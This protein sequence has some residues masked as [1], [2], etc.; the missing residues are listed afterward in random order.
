MKSTPRWLIGALAGPLLGVGL[1]LLLAPAS[2]Q[3][4]TVS[5]MAN[6]AYLLAFLMH[7]GLFALAYGV[8]L[9]LLQPRRAIAARSSLACMAVMA[10]LT[11]LHLADQL[12]FF[13]Q[14]APDRY[15]VRTLVG[16]VLAMMVGGL[17]TWL[18][19]LCGNIVASAT[20]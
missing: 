2:G 7:I 4:A 20:A 8:V 18:I 3:G 10:A 1:I 19:G 6:I 17:A 12:G 15:A 9:P 13:A 11:A 14:A 16:S 5:G